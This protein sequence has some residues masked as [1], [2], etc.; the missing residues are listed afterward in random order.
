MLHH[1]TLLGVPEATC[2]F[3]QESRSMTHS[4]DLGGLQNILRKWL[5]ATLSLCQKLLVYFQIAFVGILG[6]VQASGE[7]H[8]PSMT[9]KWSPET[10]IRLCGMARNIRL[11]PTTKDEVVMML[12]SLGTVGWSNDNIDIGTDKIW[13][14]SLEG[15]WLCRLHQG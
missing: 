6:L 5:E 4:I 2:R 13:Y 11:W 12:K 8:R 3:F 14:P 10:S 15:H 7:G 9:W 1:K